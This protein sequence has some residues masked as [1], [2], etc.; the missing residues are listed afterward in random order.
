MSAEAHAVGEQLAALYRDIHRA[1]MSGVPICNEALEVEAIGFRSFGAYALG[2][3]VTPWFANI[4]VAATATSPE[5][6]PQASAIRLRFPAGDVDFQASELAGFGR[7]ASCSLFSPMT[8]FVDQAAARS[9]AQA[10]LDA[11]FD[12]RL[13]DAPEQKEQSRERGVDRRALF[14]GRRRA[15]DEEA[16]P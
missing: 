16:A 5:P 13:L 8:E 14:G 15:H 6:L 2:V 7:I 3:V 1:A 11:L 12:P 4:I 10:A 9:A